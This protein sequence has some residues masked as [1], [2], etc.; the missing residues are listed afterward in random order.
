MDILRKRRMDTTIIQLK[1]SQLQENQISA[2]RLNPIVTDPSSNLI[3]LKNFI[4]KTRFHANEI[5]PGSKGTTGLTVKDHD[6][7][8]I[9]F[10]F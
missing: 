3:I 10:N 5:S 4:F 2:I 1:P 7:F 8:I 6:I 9:L